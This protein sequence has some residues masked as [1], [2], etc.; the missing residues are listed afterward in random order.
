MIQTLRAILGRII[1]VFPGGEW[2]LA[3]TDP[4]AISHKT[5]RGAIGERAD[6]LTGTVLDVGCGMKP[7]R[8]LFRR[9]DLYVGLDWPN[10]AFA[11]RPALDV[12][13]DAMRLPFKDASVDGVLSSEVLEHVPDPALFMREVERVLRPDGKLLLTTPQTWG[14]HEE[15]RD[16]YRFTRYGLHHLASSAGLNVIEVEP[17]TGLWG[18][19]A[20]RVVD[21]VAFNYAAGANEERLRLLSIL[22]SPVLILGHLLD[23]LVGVRGDT[24]DNV[25]VAQKGRG[26]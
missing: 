8:S 9:A 20:Q 22:L 5:L 11:W 16:F 10:T 19:F 1:R 3:W 26:A 2:L 7:Y 15:P 13:G 4:H 21:T 12:Y 17:T 6:L 14:L 23:R 25:L 24:L 18:T